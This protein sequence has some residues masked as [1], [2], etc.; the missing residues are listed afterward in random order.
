MEKPSTEDF[1]MMCGR[2][3]T[4]AEA[5]SLSRLVENTDATSTRAALSS[6]IPPTWSMFYELLK[7]EKKFGIP[8]TGTAIVCV[9]LCTVLIG[10]YFVSKKNGNTGNNRADMD[11]FAMALYEAMIS[12]TI[13]KY[14]PNVNDN[15]LAFISPEMRTVCNE[16]FEEEI[17]RYLEITRGLSI[18]S[19]DKL[20]EA[21]DSV[22]D[23]EDKT[24]N[25]ELSV[26]RSEEKESLKLVSLSDVE[27]ENLSKDSEKK[28]PL[29]KRVKNL[30]AEEEAAYRAK[31]VA[32]AIQ[33]SQIKKA[34]I[35]SKIGGGVQNF[36]SEMSAAF[37][38]FES[39]RS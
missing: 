25:V 28:I 29:P 24:Q 26:V 11:D 4:E 39:E 16:V 36:R 17:P 13:D 8:H 38:M 18:T 19:L 35:M 33:K 32:E 22:F 12:G 21:E 6:A 9:D 27:K 34:I 15:F 23:P 31:K 30:T 7:M 2:C 10:K 20:M 37:S 1:A 14:D 5:L 3:M